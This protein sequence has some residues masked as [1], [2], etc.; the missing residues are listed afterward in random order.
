MTLRRPAAAR[1]AFTLLIPLFAPS[2]LGAQVTDTLRPPPDTAADS[3]AAQADTVVLP[4]AIFVPLTPSDSLRRTDELR[5]FWRWDREEMLRAGV[6]TLADLLSRIP[7]LPSFR[8]GLA[9]Q[10]EALGELAGGAGRLEILRDGFVLDPLSSNTLDLTTLTI[11]ELEEV[12]LERHAGRLRLNLITA[13]PTDPRPYSRVEAGIGEPEIQTFRG[14]FLTP[15]FLI[16]P[17]SFGVEN[18]DTDGIGRDEPADAFTAWIRWGMQAEDRGI[19]AELRQARVRRAPGVPWAADQSRRDLIVRARNRFLPD[20]VG[21]VFAGSSRIEDESRS[22]DQSEA[23]IYDRTSAQLGARLGYDDG[24][25]RILAA[26]RYRDAEYL[27][28]LQAD[29]ETSFDLMDG[30]VT[31]EGAVSSARWDAIGT[32]TLIGAGAMVRPTAFM[33]AFAGIE[34]GSQGLAA[35][36]DP[37]PPLTGDPDPLT[38][39]AALRSGIGLQTDDPSGV[40][41]PGG[42]IRSDLS[43]MRA[44]VELDWRAVRL[45]G[46]VLDLSTDSVASFALPFDTTFRAFAGGDTRGWEAWGRLDLFDLWG[47]TVYAEGGW[48]HWF[49]GRRAAYQPLARGNAGLGAH[50]LPLESGNLEVR[51]RVWVDHRGNM[52]APSPEGAGTLLRLPARNT[53]SADLMLRIIDVRIFARLEDWRGEHMT[54]V[55]GRTVR[56][57]RIFYGVKWH[58]W[59]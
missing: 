3:L 46:A 26:A 48:L 35:W 29:V 27:P 33:R 51:G 42:P 9:L 57:P 16:G 32:T 39:S 56:G 4:P 38:S 14:L 22:P 45:G 19:Q 25:R 7:G 18:V 20:L 54:D 21:E 41:R 6:Y 53:I 8:T 31:V 49:D 58:F 23:R 52:S 47:G 13:Q 34:R 50:I 11:V 44:G 30:R 59:N 37:Q 28:T 12:V 17:F 15:R 43:S 10:P 40:L 2:G 1:A 36:P 24:S 55:P 5:G